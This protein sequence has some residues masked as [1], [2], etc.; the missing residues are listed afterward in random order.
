MAG[1]RRSEKP[2]LND[3]ETT[4]TQRQ[5]TGSMRTGL[6][7][8]EPLAVVGNSWNPRE[9]AGS[10]HRR[11]E[12]TPRSTVVMLLSAT[13]HNGGFGFS[14]GGSSSGREAR[15]AQM[16]ASRCLSP[17]DRFRTQGVASTS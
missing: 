13:P 11:T 7:F 16:R 15:D 12:P 6:D 4:T 10:E 2:D 17:P 1:H 14:D 9:E 8:N 3:A 5:G